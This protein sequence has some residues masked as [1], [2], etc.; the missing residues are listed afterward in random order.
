MR[1]R[2]F[3]KSLSDEIENL[4]ESL[5]EKYQPEEADKL[6]QSVPIKDILERVKNLD[7]E[8]HKDESK[9]T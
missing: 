1:F 4:I 8:Q 2:E 3:S 5:G 6:D 7:I 9:N